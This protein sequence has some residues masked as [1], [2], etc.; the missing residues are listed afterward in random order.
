MTPQDYIEDLI[1][2][3]KQ[4]EASSLRKDINSIAFLAVRA[5]V[6]AAID[7]GFTS[8]TIWT[9]LSERGE[10]S[11]RYETFLKHVR[12]HITQAPTPLKE[13]PLEQEVI[14]KPQPIAPLRS[15]TFNPRPN[16]EDLI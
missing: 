14:I 5:H 8:K 13:S 16:K 2:W 6:K 10:I 7:T 9:H 12:R 15:F 11:Y 4:R 1:S 3:V